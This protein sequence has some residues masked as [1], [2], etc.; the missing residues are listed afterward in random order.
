LQETQVVT[1]RKGLIHQSSSSYCG[2]SFLSLCIFNLTLMQFKALLITETAEGKYERKIVQR[3]LEELPP[4]EVLVRVHYSALNYKDG[5]S[6]TGHKG[7]TK[8]FPHTPGIEA[9]GQV[10]ESTSSRFKPGNGVF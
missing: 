10:I 9:A 7:I 8:S 1:T 6:A 3:D 2:Y 5:L 4:N